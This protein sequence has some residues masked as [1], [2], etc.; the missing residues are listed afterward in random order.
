MFITNWIK[1]ELF[2]VLLKLNNENMGHYNFANFITPITRISN[3]S[4][5]LLNDILTNLIPT[6]AFLLV[7]FAYFF[8]KNWK[9]GI[10]FL[11]ANIIIIIYLGLMWETIFHC[12]KEQEK[13]VVANETY[14]LDNLNNIEK[15]IYR[16]E[17]NSEINIFKNKT[18]KCIEFTTN[19][20]N[21]I[22]NQT[23]I[24]NGMVYF[25]IF[26]SL[27]YCIYLQTTKKIDT[28]TFITLL[29]MI[30]MYR[31]NISD[32]IQSIPYNIESA[33]RIELIAKDFNDMIGN[34]DLSEFLNKIVEYKKI[35]LP[36]DKIVFKNVSFRY[37]AESTPIFHNF[38]KEVL[39][40]DKIIGVVGHSGNGKSSFMKLILRLHDCTAGEILIDDINIKLIDPNYIRENITYVNQSSKLFDRKVL[41][42]I[43]YGCKDIEKCNRNLKEI[44]TYSKIRDLYK[45]VDFNETA[46][47]LGENLSGGQRQIANIIS[48]LI[49]PT[50]VLILDEPTN[51]LDPE[52]K[53]S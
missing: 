50:K 47:P 35:E 43:Y 10:G 29:T 7:M 3:S 41:E 18:D 24:M 25:T 42:N 22:T 28:I 17:I 23:F 16:G 8:L 30:I 12:K 2:S 38:N 4:S 1:Q 20:M 27:Y 48:G 19:L 32:T 52:L 36:F 34:V 37:S 46:G 6:I 9:L 15:V 14:I 45:N 13:M 40:N 33:C 21:F 39:I 53:G 26:G 49:N 31:D 51:A 5:V 44:L 11:I